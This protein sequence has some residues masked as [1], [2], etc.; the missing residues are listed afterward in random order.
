MLAVGG[1]LIPAG[2]A[3][4]VAYEQNRRAIQNHLTQDLLSA[5]NQSAGAMGVWLLERAYDLRV[6]ASSDEVLNNLNRYAIGQGSI[7]SARLRE[8]LRSLHDRFT[9]FDQIMVLDSRGRLLATSA[10]QTR[11]VTLPTDWERVLR[12]QQQLVVDPYWDAKDKK[13]KLMIAVPVRGADGRLIGSLAAE[14]N[15]S[16]VLALLKSYARDTITGGAHLVT[17]KGAL[18]ASTR[19][20]TKELLASRLER[21]TQARLG[22]AEGRSLTYRNHTGTDVIGTYKRV[23]GFSWAVVSELSQATA[24]EQVRQFR[25]WALLGVGFVL[26]VIAITA[27]RLGLLIVRPLERL[28]AGAAEVSTGDLSVDL[29][30]AGGGEVGVLTRVF[31]HMVARLRE[32]R[33]EL[34]SANETLRLKNEELERL[35]VTD[36]LTGLSNHRSLMQ[37]LTDEGVRTKRSKKP[38]SIIMADVDFFKAYNDDFGHP[39]GD[40]VLKRMGA[41]LRDMTRSMDSVARYGGEEFAILLPETSV[42]GAR[43]VA[44]RIRER[45]ESTTFAHRSV[46]VSIGVAEYPKHGDSPKAA[47]KAADVALYHAKRG[48]RNQVAHARLTAGKE[49]L[50]AARSAAKRRA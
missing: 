11:P 6:F 22:R 30:N 46:T 10:R 25:N 31:N 1:A 9:D 33:Q 50:P 49:V 23:P 34:A 27:Y 47:L 48:G 2:I 28:A 32:G 7:P 39:A 17:G 3:L 42:S 35:S 14:L 24:F 15:L 12:Q 21:R 18:I 37:R 44:E 38:M 4:G 16:P 8:Y 26:I 45:V 20:I 29:P 19:G 40:E 5:G 41:I 43:E 36:G 13:G